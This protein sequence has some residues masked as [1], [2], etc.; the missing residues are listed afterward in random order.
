LFVIVV[1]ESWFYEPHLIFISPSLVM[2]CAG[3]FGALFLVSD[4][5][6]EMR[7]QERG[8]TNYYECDTINA[9][10]HCDIKSSYEYRYASTMSTGRAPNCLCN[11]IILTRLGLSL[12]LLILSVVVIIISLFRARHFQ[13][14]QQDENDDD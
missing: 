4:V 10:H 5:L 2:Q 6:L 7:G 11:I 9:A 1:G 13:L 8:F 12:D 14:L 3:S